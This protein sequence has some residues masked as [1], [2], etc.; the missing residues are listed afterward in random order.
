VA[1]HILASV[2]LLGLST[3]MLV[4]AT[5]G[6]R[7]ADPATAHAAYRSMGFFTPGVVPP[8]A[9]AA[10][11]TGIVLALGTKWG[12]FTHVWIVTKLG[13]T[14]ATILCGIFVISPAVE[15]AIA[16]NPPTVLVAAAALNVLMLGA[17]TVISVFKPWGMLRRGQEPARSAQ[18]SQLARSTG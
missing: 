8:V 18:S 17:A 6:A 11:I 2:G 15:E 12:L 1:A 9:M 13:L 5:A 16:G 4:L 10:L 14:L 3:A 7:T